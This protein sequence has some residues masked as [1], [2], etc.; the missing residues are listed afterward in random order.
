ML[1]VGMKVRINPD[2]VFEESP[3]TIDIRKLQRD[4]V[5]GEICDY[6][7]DAEYPYMAEFAGYFNNPSFL[8][9][10]ESE[11]IPVEEN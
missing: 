6:D 8:V 2:A 1:T 7:A 5:V 10:L 11:L 3:L 9:F 4:Q